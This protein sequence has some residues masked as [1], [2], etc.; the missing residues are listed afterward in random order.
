MR[1]EVDEHAQLHQRTEVQHGGEEN[2]ECEAHGTKV[3]Q[4]CKPAATK[5]VRFVR[6]FI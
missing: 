2:N 6:D 5:E 4:T 3:Q 1:G